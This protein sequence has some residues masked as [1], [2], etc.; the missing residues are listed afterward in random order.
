MDCDYGEGSTNWHP[1]ALELDH[2]PGTAK[3]KAVSEMHGYSAERIL[4]E[5]NKCDV[6][7]ANCHRVRTAKRRNNN[8]VSEEPTD[9]LRLTLDC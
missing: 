6:V 3:I 5:I 4:E 9:Q 2:R 8:T 7:C 1:D